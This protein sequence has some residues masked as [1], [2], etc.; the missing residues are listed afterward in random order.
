VKLAEHSHEE[1]I[2]KGNRHNHGAARFFHACDELG[3]RIFFSEH[4]AGLLAASATWSIPVFLASQDHISLTYR[5]TFLQLSSFGLV[6]IVFNIAYLI[7]EAKPHLLFL[8]AVAV[9]TLPMLAIHALL[10][11]IVFT[12]EER[13]EIKSLRSQRTRVA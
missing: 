8:I 6:M 4:V 11:R 7:G 3:P 1:R 10:E 13:Q 9:L 2:L 12:D 5:R